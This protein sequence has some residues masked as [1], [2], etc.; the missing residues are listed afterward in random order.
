M[1]APERFGP[2]EFQ[3]ATDV[4]R[5]TLERLMVFVDLLQRWQER[6]NLIAASTV[7]AVWHRHVLDSAQL[8]VLAPATA[9]RWVDL[10]AG[11]GFPGVVIAILKTGEPGF[12]MHLI[13]RIARKCEF[14]AA[15]ARA[16]A[17]PITVHKGQIAEV[18]PVSADVVAARACAPLAQLLP[19]YLRHRA[20][21]GLGLF[22][23][24]RSAVQ[25]LTQ[26]EALW[27]LGRDILPSRTDSDSR[28]LRIRSAQKRSDGRRSR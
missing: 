26:V 16:T 19:M 5:E 4:S 23:K 6:L 21:T 8:A 25:E 2:A 18:E 10:G 14:L 17:A 27:T 28:I 12:E 22:A 15:A 11:G 13:E 1:S 24:G 9:R 7:P 3:A 20:P